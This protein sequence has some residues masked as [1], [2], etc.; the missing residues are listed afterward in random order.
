MTQ[1]VEGLDRFFTNLRHKI[2]EPCG[3]YLDVQNWSR[4]ELPHQSFPL[5]QDTHN[6]KVFHLRSTFESTHLEA[7]AL[8]SRP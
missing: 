1:E 7:H 5:P 2:N 6:H 8:R 4:K 3:L